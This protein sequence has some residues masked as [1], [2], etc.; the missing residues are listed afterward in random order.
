MGRK[1]CMRSARLCLKVSLLLHIS[2]LTYMELPILLKLQFFFWKM[3]LKFNTV[4]S[5]KIEFVK[6]FKRKPQD[7]TFFF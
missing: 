1:K 3:F 5:L 7:K 2:F 6:N 4:H